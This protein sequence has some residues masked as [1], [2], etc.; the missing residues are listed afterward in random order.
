MPK[1]NY[2]NGADEHFFQRLAKVAQENNQ[3]LPTIAEVLDSIKLTLNQHASELL[4]DMQG[5][6]IQRLVAQLYDYPEEIRSSNSPNQLSQLLVP[7]CYE[8]FAESGEMYEGTFERKPRLWEI[9]AC[10]AFVSVNKENYLSDAPAELLFKE[11]TPDLVPAPP[12]PPLPEKPIVLASYPPNPEDLGYI[13]L[14]NLFDY[15]R[16]P[17]LE[18][19]IDLDFD[20]FF[21]DETSEK[22]L[23]FCLVPPGTH[24]VNVS[25]LDRSNTTWCYLQP[26]QVLVLELKSAKRTYTK[27]R[28]FEANPE[29]TAHYQNLAT[30]GALELALLPYVKYKIE[31]KPWYRSQYPW[32]LI[33]QHIRPPQIPPTV[34]IEQLGTAVDNLK[35]QQSHGGD[36]MTFLAEF[37][38]TFISGYLT[39]EYSHMYRWNQLLQVLCYSGEEGIAY[40]GERL[41]EV[42]DIVMVQLQKTL[43]NYIHSHSEVFDACEYLIDDLVKSAI[44]IAVEKGQELAACIES[45]KEWIAEDI[46]SGKL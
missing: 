26:R 27:L 35:L 40:L 4:S 14:L 8:S 33:T 13:I 15:L 44:P 29:T 10:V 2:E 23:G 17:D 21:Y 31:E 46:S 11:I 38:F 20:P 39:F 30:T 42:I 37:E 34:Q 28:F 3:P 22:F 12:P 25:F 9:L 43:N 1:C 19:G 24:T 6:H 5:V 36:L 45:K 16:P 32:S 18:R 41:P 7:E